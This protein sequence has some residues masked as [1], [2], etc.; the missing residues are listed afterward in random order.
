MEIPS[1][2]HLVAPLTRQIIRHEFKDIDPKLPE[3]LEILSSHGADECWH[4]HG[5]FKEHLFGTWRCVFTNLEFGFEFWSN[6]S[7]EV[8]LVN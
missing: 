4:K 2:A 1:S 6:E 8:L 5:T 7:Q 3:Y